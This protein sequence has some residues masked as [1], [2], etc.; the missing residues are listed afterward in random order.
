MGYDPNRENNGINQLT[1]KAIGP[2]LSGAGNVQSSILQ[3]AET[4]RLQ[5]ELMKQWAPKVRTALKSSAGRFQHGKS[6]SFVLRHKGDQS[7]GKLA[8]SI[9]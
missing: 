6:E 8:N 4:T 3:D 7:E 5:N 9:K 1:G 2:R